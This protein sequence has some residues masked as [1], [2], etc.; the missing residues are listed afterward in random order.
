MA[1]STGRFDAVAEGKRI[2]VNIQTRATARP[3]GTTD[4]CQKL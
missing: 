3:G 4:T 2:K 1:R